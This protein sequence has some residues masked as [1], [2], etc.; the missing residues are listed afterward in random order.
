MFPYFSDYFWKGG[1]PVGKGLLAD[2][3][4]HSCEIAYRIVHDSFQKHVTVEK[5][6]NG[7]FVEVIYDSLLLDF[8]KLQPERQAVWKKEIISQTATEEKSLIRDE[9]DRILYKELYHFHEGRCHV[10]ETRSCHGLLLSRQELSYKNR[11]DSFD[12][13]ILYDTNAHPVMSKQYTLDEEG[14][15]E[16]VTKECWDY[17]N[18]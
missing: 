4:W 3:A 9:T 7:S 6:A 8:R 12:G 2:E 14:Q 15:F 18:A 5:Y 10:C 16:Q 11:G 13:M 17:S 1:W